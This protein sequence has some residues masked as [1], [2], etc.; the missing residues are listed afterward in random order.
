VVRL[1]YT[2]DPEKDAEWVEKNKPLYPLDKW[3]QEFELKRTSSSL[4]VWPDFDDT[5]HVV[6][7]EWQCFPHWEIIVG[8]DPGFDHPFACVFLAAQSDGTITVFCEH[9]QRKQL[10]SEHVTDIVSI[11]RRHL[12]VPTEVS[13]EKL[14]SRPTWIIDPSQAQTI[15]ELSQFGIHAMKSVDRNIRINDVGSGVNRVGEWLRL[16]PDGTARI[17]FLRPFTRALVNE[18]KEYQWERTSMGQPKKD[19]VKKVKD[20]LCDA[21]RYALMARPSINE[22]PR[23]KAGVGTMQE[24]LLKAQ[25]Q[26][27]NRKKR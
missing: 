25:K 5:K 21:L 13:D 18:M 6:D 27:R 1:H 12:N 22:T 15:H 2:A 3:E 24:M 11:L 14:L 4:L 16:R 8:V 10:I 19:K 9:R 17:R 7:V 20:D 26:Y 23:L